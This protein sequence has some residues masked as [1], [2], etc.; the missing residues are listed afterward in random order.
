MATT[1]I[2]VT[3]SVLEPKTDVINSERLLL[4]WELKSNLLQDKENTVLETLNG[5]VLIAKEEPSVIHALDP[6]VD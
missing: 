4:L 3:Y 2:D 1:K 5:F 6:D